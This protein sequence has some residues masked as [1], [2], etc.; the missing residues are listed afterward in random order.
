MSVSKH[1]NAEEVDHEQSRTSD[2]KNKYFSHIFFVEPKVPVEELKK[3]QKALGDLKTENRN[4]RKQLLLKYQKSAQPDRI[5]KTL[6]DMYSEVLDE[7]S[8]LDT[9]YNI[10]DH[11]PRVVVVGDQS[12][13]KT[14]VLEMIAQARIFPRGSGEMMT[15]SP[16]KVTLSEGPYHVAAFRDSPKEYDLTNE[17]ELASLRNEIELRMQGLVADG[18]TISTEVI[19]LSVK[20]PGL[21]RMVL[22]DLPGIISTQTTGMELGARESIRKL[23]KQYMDN[24]NAIILYGS[25]DAERSNVTDLVASVDPQGKR[26]IFVLTKVDLAEANLYN[27][28]R[29]R[30]ILEGRLF[31]MKAL[32]YY[33]VVTG[34]GSKDESIESIKEYEAEFFKKSR[35][36]REGALKLAQMTTENMS[37]AVSERFWKMVKDSVEQEA[38]TYRGNLYWLS[39][40]SCYFHSIES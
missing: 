26:T 2:G 5:K 35:L 27:P 22:V 7:L 30:E 34:K 13:G 38:D 9:D 8:N 33:A 23:V 15:R 29:I 20:G 39:T 16:V 36:F 4:L 28:N 10:Q 24:P 32:G 21:Q 1:T 18:K 6:I 19:S 17:T 37:K 11:L 40:T 12:S 3:Y 31:P 25:I 14:S